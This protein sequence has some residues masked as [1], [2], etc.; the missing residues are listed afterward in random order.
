MPLPVAAGRQPVEAAA[1]GTATA[2]L[3]QQQAHPWYA[4]CYLQSA[5]IIPLASRYTSR[6]GVGTMTLDGD[7][8]W[9]S[10][11][12]VVEPATVK[13]RRNA[14]PTRAVKPSDREVV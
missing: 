11:E 6:Q 5:T 7:H 9:A 3:K 13:T 2:G 4:I 12:V 1:R 8:G 14:V 10:H